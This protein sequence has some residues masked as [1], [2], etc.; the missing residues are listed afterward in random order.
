M[1]SLSHIF[2]SISFSLIKA[3]TVEYEEAILLG[4][5]AVKIRESPTFDGHTTCIS[6]VKE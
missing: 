5:T 6:W 2:S 3:V 4:C 1:L